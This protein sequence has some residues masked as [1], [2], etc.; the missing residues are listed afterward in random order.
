MLRINVLG[1]FEAMWSDGEP[2][3]LVTRKAQALL[4]Y[5]AVEHDRPHTRD[6]LATM[7][8]ADTG[9]DRARHLLSIGRAVPSVTD[10]QYLDLRNGG[11][12]GQCFPQL[13]GRRQRGLPGH[14]LHGRN[15][16]P[17]EVREMERNVMGRDDRR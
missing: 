7:L 3:G 15:H 11:Q 5:L 1:R 8:W 2:V 14:R 12:P 16:P 9:D 13:A 17:G 6:Q 4:A 10:W